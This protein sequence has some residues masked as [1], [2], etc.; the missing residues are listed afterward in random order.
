[1]LFLIPSI[2]P[3]NKDR[4]GFQPHSVSIYNDYG[5][6]CRPVKLELG[7]LATSYLVTS[8]AKQRPT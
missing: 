4:E 5:L 1:M 8:S 3:Y 6:E 2:D 7:C